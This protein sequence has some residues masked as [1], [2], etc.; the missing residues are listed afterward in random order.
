M[1]K[2]KNAFFSPLGSWD[3]FLAALGFLGGPCALGR[4]LCS[5]WATLGLPFGSSAL[6]PWALR[7]PLGSWVALGLLGGP[8]ALGW[9]LGSWVVLGLLGGLGSWALEESKGPRRAQDES[10]GPRRA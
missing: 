10:K 6:D 1:L 7:W 9:P 4:P 2:V 8:W 3:G 5:S